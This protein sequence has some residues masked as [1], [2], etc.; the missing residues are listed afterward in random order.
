MCVSEGFLLG[1]FGLHI[2][3][4]HLVVVVVVVFDSF[5]RSP[6]QLVLLGIFFFFL[7]FLLGLACVVTL[8]PAF[9][10]PSAHKVGAHVR[11]CVCVHVRCVCMCACA[12]CV[13]KSVCMWRGTLY[14]CVTVRRPCPTPL[15]V[16]SEEKEILLLICSVWFTHTHTHTPSLPPSLP[17]LSISIGTRTRL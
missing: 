15:L 1:C 12:V 11:M 10:E 5:A 7:L 9:A 2:L 4:C 14:Q 17:P 6:H 8:F 13:C 16:A 3:P